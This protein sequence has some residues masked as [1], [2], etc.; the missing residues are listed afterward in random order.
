MSTTWC[1]LSSQ[2][3][4]LPLRDTTTTTAM[5]ICKQRTP[6]R[7]SAT[8]PTTTTATTA[9][10]AAATPRP[11]RRRPLLNKGMPPPHAKPTTST[12]RSSSQD[13][14]PP[15]HQVT[16]D[17]ELSLTQISSILDPF[18]DTCIAVRQQHQRSL[19]ATTAAAV[20]PTA[21]IATREFLS[22]PLQGSVSVVMGDAGDSGSGA[23]VGQE[24][25]GAAAALDSSG[26]LQDFLGSGNS[27]WV[28]AIQEMEAEKQQNDEK[29]VVRRL[30][31]VVS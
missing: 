17:P 24:T 21:T 5:C 13:Q 29:K 20:A 9:A 18:F 25:S 23:M 31:V 30:N 7:K 11:S 8:T 10:P 2:E 27:A 15:V 16:P 1:F 26:A 19:A 28:G 12:K 14:Q 6:S 3:S 22:P 4:R